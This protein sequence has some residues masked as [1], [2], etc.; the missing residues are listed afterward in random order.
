MTR[1][2]TIDSLAAGGDGVGRDS[3]GRVTFV[4]Y[5]APGDQLKI[6]L[7][8]EKKT[9]AWGQIDQLLVPSAVRTSPQ[10]GLFSRQVCGGCAWQHVSYAAQAEAK[11]NIVTAALRIFS[12][13]DLVIEPIRTP[14]DAYAWRRRARLHW[15]RSEAQTATTLGFYGPKSNDLVDVNRCPQLTTVLGTALEKIRQLLLPHLR[16]RGEL[17]LLAGDQDEVHIAIHGDCSPD[18][19]EL[20]LTT[21]IVGVS[22]PGLQLGRVP[23]IDGVPHSADQ[24]CQSSRQGNQALLD[25]VR[26]ASKPRQGLKI[27]EFFAGTGNLTRI[28]AD[29]A[30]H[31]TAIDKI[32]L[33]PKERTANIKFVRGDVLRAAKGLV[34][35]KTHVDLV[36]LDPPRQ[37]AAALVPAL[38]AL[39]PKRI[40]YVSCDPATLARDARMLAD[41]YKPV[42]A[43][44]IDL[45]PQTAHVE[46]VLALEEIS[47][48]V[49]NT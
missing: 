14:V 15:K 30:A 11:Q 21:P 39:K 13:T 42:H 29:G 36:V 8:R 49:S 48:C 26:E 45:M 27:I 47:S 28:L 40:L 12:N 17:F 16:G 6:V 1:S 35:R 3:T 32:A 44:P 24:F 31:V 7:T 41:N 9:V 2:I 23:T 38:R 46:I 37:G 5:S 4:P 18:H 33:K 19:A 43:Y 25:I 20:L 34:D 10:C 22:A